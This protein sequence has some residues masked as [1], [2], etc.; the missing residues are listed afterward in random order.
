MQ[1]KSKINPKAFK[2]II[3][4]IASQPAKANSVSLGGGFDSILMKNLNVVIN[5][6]HKSPQGYLDDMSV[7]IMT[8]FNWFEKLAREL[9]S[10]E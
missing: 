3:I 7:K 2:A 9:D 6:A 1:L 8:G 4:N 10:T 5:Y